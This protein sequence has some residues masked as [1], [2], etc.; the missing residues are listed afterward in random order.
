MASFGA[1]WGDLLHKIQQWLGW[2]KPKKKNKYHDRNRFLQHPAPFR[3]Y[4]GH[5]TEA[6]RYPYTCFAYGV[7][8]TTERVAVHYLRIRPFMDGRDPTIFAG[9]PNRQRLALAILA[10]TLA[11]EN[12]HFWQILLG[13][14][15]THALRFGFVWRL[16]GESVDILYLPLNLS[17]PGHSSESL[18]RE[19]SEHLTEL[20]L[21]EKIVRLLCPPPDRMRAAQ[22][23]WLSMLFLKWRWLVCDRY[24]VEPL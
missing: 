5:Y 13:N 11:P 21:K 2:K 4:R 18:A 24:R 19:C 15:P 6:P 16:T 10:T 20:L 23:F 17:Q 8:P 22:F 14:P 7:L 9:V 12:K 1:V 3:A